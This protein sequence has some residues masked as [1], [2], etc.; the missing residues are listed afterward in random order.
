MSSRCLGSG[1]MSA[2]LMHGPWLLDVFVK[3]TAGGGGG[4]APC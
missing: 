2:L 3:A 4:H 1:S